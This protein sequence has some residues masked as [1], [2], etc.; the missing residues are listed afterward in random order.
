MQKLGYIRYR[1][2]L[3]VS[4]S[5]VKWALTR[6]RVARDDEASQPIKGWMREQII[7]KK[8]NVMIKRNQQKKYVTAKHAS[9]PDAVVYSQK[10]NQIDRRK[11]QKANTLQHF[12]NSSQPQECSASI[13]WHW[14]DLSMHLRSLYHTD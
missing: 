2:S 14:T 4:S 7:K 6:I 12:P 1:R 11:S 10:Q 13:H 8:N 5:L 9:C 3:I